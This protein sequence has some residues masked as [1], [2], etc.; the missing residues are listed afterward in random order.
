[1]DKEPSRTVEGAQDKDKSLY[2]SDFKTNKLNV[3]A[4]LIHYV[5]RGGVRWGGVEK[6]ST[7]GE[8]EVIR[9]YLSFT[10]KSNV[11]CIAMGKAVR[12]Q[13]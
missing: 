12:V 5:V 3:E 8:L 2:R 11:C 4:W 7:P 13:M 9:T 6:S 10:R 1:M